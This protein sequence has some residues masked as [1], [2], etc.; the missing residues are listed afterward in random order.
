M[1][2]LSVRIRIRLANALLQLV[3]LPGVY[4]VRRDHGPFGSMCVCR[5]A[6][7]CIFRA[8]VSWLRADD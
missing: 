3:D 4:T 5:H 7:T 1:S 8:E 6:G 2:H